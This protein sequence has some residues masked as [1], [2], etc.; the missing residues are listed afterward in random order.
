MQSFLQKYVLEI[1]FKFINFLKDL[2]L[3]TKFKC[4]NFFYKKNIYDYNYLIFPSFSHQIF[5]NNFYFIFWR[6]K[7]EKA[8]KI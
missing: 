3:V 8:I 7:N 1:Y 6:E 4:Y 5:L 2:K